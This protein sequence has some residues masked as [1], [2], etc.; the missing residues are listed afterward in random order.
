[1]AAKRTT[2]RTLDLQAM[3]PQEIQIPIE[4]D[5]E[6]ESAELMRVLEEMH[7]AG[8][9]KVEIYRQLS[10]GKDLRYIDEMP[11]ANYSIAMLKHPPYNG[12]K[13]RIY[14]RNADGKIVANKMIEVES[15]PV[16][17]TIAPPAAP[18]IQQA[19]DMT[20]LVAAIAAGFTKL[21]ELVVVSARENRQE[22]RT[23]KDIL[24]ELRAYQDVFGKPAAEAPP[25]DSLDNLDKMFGILEKLQAFSGGGGEKTTLESMLD[26]AK[27]IVPSIRDAI[28]QEHQPESAP[29]LAAPAAQQGNPTQAPPQPTQREQAAMQ[30]KMQLMFLCSQASR[31]NDPSTYA[32]L[33][34]DMVPKHILMQYVDRED[35]F[36]Q[37]AALQ[38]AVAQYR[39][40][41][42]E[43]RAIALSILTEEQQS[44]QTPGPNGSAPGSDDVPS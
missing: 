4:E 30:L 34:V 42:T 17:P 31:N 33:V 41:F 36:E 38:P 1:M 8:N 7:D 11:P 32:G 9:S 44:A 6:P 23:T 27:F 18:Q 22:Q 43:L 25:R 35:W 24:E 3:P 13:F 40:W 20:P 5:F 37:L 29:A 14:V 10:H 12:G 16:A 28:Q 2:A 21:G 39:E 15:A 19:A 26:F